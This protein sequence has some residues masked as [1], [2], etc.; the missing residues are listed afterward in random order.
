MLATEGS[1]LYR[2]LDLIS[3]LPRDEC[4]RRLQAAIGPDWIFMGSLFTA[5]PCIGSVSETTLRLRVRIRYRNSFQTHLYATLADADGHTQLH[6]RFGTHPSVIVFMSIWFGFVVL[7]A[8]AMAIKASAAAF[9]PLGLFVFGA[10][11]VLVCRA[12]ARDEQDQLIEFLETTID[13]HEAG[14]EPAQ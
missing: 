9:V 13:A 7:A 11:L 2:Y 10:I 1:M 3:P 6:C 5:K 4:V 14:V 12:V 8:I